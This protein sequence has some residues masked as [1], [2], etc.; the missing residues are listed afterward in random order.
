M[1]LSTSRSG[2]RFT[3]LTL[4]NWRNFSACD[5][6]L[7]PRAFLVG[8]NASGKSNLLD[9]FRF[10]HDIVSV[11]G[12]LQK[13][14]RDRGGVSSLRSLHARRHPGVSIDVVIGT[15]ERPQSW[16]Y[17]LDI[18]KRSRNDD[19]VVEVERVWRNG[20]LVIERPNKE[21]QRDRQRLSQTVIEQIA[22]NADFREVAAFFQSVRY[23]HVSPQFIRDPLRATRSADAY[24]GDLIRVM[25]ETPEKTRKAR[26][27][28]IEQGLQIAVP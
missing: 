3:H 4:R 14:V 8:P 15:D 6:Q 10:L 13:A 2:L 19:A 9:V 28:R 17:R 18:N 11:G 21:D 12:G 26:L 16:R 20:T 5:V 7:G 1:A 24:G 25:A 23:L 22:A 27:K